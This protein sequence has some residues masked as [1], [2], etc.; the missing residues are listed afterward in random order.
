MNA[1][2]ETRQ[3]YDTIES[4]YNFFGHSFYLLIFKKNT[5]ARQKKNKA[6]YLKMDNLK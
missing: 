4:A 1:V 6:S 2:A 5:E 3:F